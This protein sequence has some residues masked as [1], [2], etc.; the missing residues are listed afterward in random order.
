MHPYQIAVYYFPNYHIDP[1][2]ELLHGPGW[3]EWELVRHAGPRFPGHRQ[4]RVPAWG[5]EDESDPAVMAK[6]IDAAADHAVTQ[7]LFDWYWYDDGP[8]LNRGLD[9]G[10]LAAANNDRLQFALMWAN[11]DWTDIHPYKRNGPS[12]PALSRPG[13]PADLRDPD[14]LRDPALLQP[15]L[16][17]EA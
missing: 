3:T 6:K 9:E 7:F 2:N 1:R 14:R 17:L 8:F 13:H 5:Y 12:Q 10:F 16:L 4:P 11:H 15:S